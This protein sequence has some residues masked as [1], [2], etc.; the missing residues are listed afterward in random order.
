MNTITIVGR[1]GKDA[2]LRSTANGSVLS[3]SIASYVG[4]GDNKTTLWFNCSIWG[5]RAEALA[6]H[7]TKGTSVTAVGELSQREHD[8]KTYLQVRVAEIALQGGKKDGEQQPKPA[9]N[10]KPAPQPVNDA[11][12]PF[13]DDMPF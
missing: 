10:P 12:D 2:E 13:A 5:K 9:Q 7:L 1:V 4:Y 8:G 3:F 11:L 6:E